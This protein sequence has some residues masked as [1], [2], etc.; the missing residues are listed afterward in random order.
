MGIKGDFQFD[1]D[2]AD[3]IATVTRDIGGDKDNCGYSREAVHVAL[4]TLALTF[5]S[6][7]ITGDEEAAVN[8]YVDCVSV[9]S[10]LAFR[11]VGLTEYQALDL[12][13][14]LDARNAYIAAKAK[15]LLEKRRGIRGTP[16]GQ[17]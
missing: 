12:L 10:N 7:A 17:S 6:Q 4:A 1:R 13:R 5:S 2:Y 14:K 8:A 3:A 16:E 9:L 15:T 11:Q